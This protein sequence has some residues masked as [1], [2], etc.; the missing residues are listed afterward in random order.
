MSS[1]KNSIFSVGTHLVWKRTFFSNLEQCAIIILKSSWS[2]FIESSKIVLHICPD[3]ISPKQLKQKI[4]EIISNELNCEISIHEFHVWQ[5]TSSRKVASLHIKTRTDVM[6]LDS[7]TS[8]T[9]FDM[10][11]AMVYIKKVFHENGIHN[12]TVQLEKY[13]GL[14]ER[15]G[16][17]DGFT[18]CPDDEKTSCCQ[19]WI[20][21]G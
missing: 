7:N 8:H 18:C 3:N 4:I 13:D 16:C 11:V 21:F 17:E 1:H 6:E 14:E 19:K 20:R 12:I 15:F 10:T 9:N 2:L 5:L